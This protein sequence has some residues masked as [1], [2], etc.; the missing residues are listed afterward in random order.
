MKI[1]S[2][3]SG[4]GGF[5]LGLER[6]GMK[7]ISFCEIDKKCQLVLRKHWPNIPIY[8]DIKK[9]TSRKLKKDGIKK[10]DVICGG[11]PCQDLSTAGKQKGI[12]GERSGLWTEYRRLISEIRPKF[13]IVENVKS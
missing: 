10:P 3:F 11:F 2:L 6:A 5:S 4:I 12:S 7:T 1:A 8:G 9:L 13:A